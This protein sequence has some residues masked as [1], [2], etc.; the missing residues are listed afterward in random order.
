[1]QLEILIDWSPYLALAVVTDHLHPSS[2]H[3]STQRDAFV[4][5]YLFA[6]VLV[7]A[8]AGMRGACVRA[9]VLANV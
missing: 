8:R 1:M 3:T 9:C 2:P 4:F 5:V 7:R 6:C